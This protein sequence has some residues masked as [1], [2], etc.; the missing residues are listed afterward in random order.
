MTANPDSTHVYYDLVLEMHR[1]VNQEIKRVNASIS[2]S[3]ALQFAKRLNP[4]KVQKEQVTGG[5]A[6]D[7]QSLDDK[8]CYTPIDLRT[9]SLAKYP[10]LPEIGTVLPEIKRFC[11]TLCKS[12]GG[13]IKED[14]A[15]LKSRLSTCQA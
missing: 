3:C 2:P 4:Q 8:L 12:D 9:L 15:D 10:E 13:R 14:M 6:S 7:A 5:G 11:E 1:L